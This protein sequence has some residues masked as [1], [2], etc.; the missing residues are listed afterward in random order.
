[1]SNN[2]GERIFSSSNINY[3]KAFNDKKNL[4]LGVQYTNYTRDVDNSILNTFENGTISNLV[5][6]SQDFN[7]ESI[8]LKGDYSVSFAK[9]NQLEIGVNVARNVSNSQLQINQENSKYKYLETINAVYS[10]FSG[11]KENYNS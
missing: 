2:V 10:Q 7:V 3:F 1:M 5:T 6:I 11:G 4:F 8:V 9:G